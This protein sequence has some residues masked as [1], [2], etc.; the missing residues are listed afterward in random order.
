MLKIITNIIVCY[1]YRCLRELN[2]WS[3]LSDSRLGKNNVLLEIEHS[4]KKSIGNTTN[5]LN[6]RWNL[7]HK[8]QVWPS[9]LIWK[10]IFF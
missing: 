8:Q 7:E 2:D 1:V 9:T 3:F 10:V 6:L 5:S 4:W